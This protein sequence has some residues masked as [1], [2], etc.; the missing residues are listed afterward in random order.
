[1]HVLP[2]QQPPPAVPQDVGMHWP[3]VQMPD[4]PPIG[5]VPPGPTHVHPAPR[6]V[7][8]LRFVHGTLVRQQA[9][10][11]CPHCVAASPGRASGAPVSGE[12]DSAGPASAGA[13]P[14]NPPAHLAPDGHVPP[15][16]TQ[17]GLPPMT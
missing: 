11:G 12:P 10:P 3:L 15:L 9:S 14:Q 7:G 6:E 5:H 13:A 2:G 16:A 1:M 17:H 8:Q 4:D